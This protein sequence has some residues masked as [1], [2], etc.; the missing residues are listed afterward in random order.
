MYI[1]H[2]YIIKY[3]DVLFNLIQIAY[4]NI[5]QYKIIDIFYSFS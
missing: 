2:M 3:I 5:N 1:I 4:I